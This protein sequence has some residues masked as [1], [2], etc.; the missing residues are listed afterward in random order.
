MSASIHDV[1]RMTPRLVGLRGGSTLL[2]L[3]RHGGDIVRMRGDARPKH[4]ASVMWLL[5]VD[6]G[7]GQGS[8]RHVDNDISVLLPWR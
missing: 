4:L 7:V 1:M 6:K 8:E 5:A 2:D 3:D